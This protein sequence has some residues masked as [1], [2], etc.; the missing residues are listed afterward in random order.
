MHKVQHLFHGSIAWPQIASFVNMHT[1]VYVCECV[2]TCMHNYI[3]TI[4]C[5]LC[6]CVN[7]LHSLHTQSGS[8][9]ANPSPVKKNIYSKSH[10]ACSLAAKKKSAPHLTT[11]YACIQ[12]AV[13]TKNKTILVIGCK[14][15]NNKPN[16]STEYICCLCCLTQQDSKL[17]ASNTKK[18]MHTKK[19]V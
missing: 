15:W 13:W 12:I 8:E 5:M 11:M 1:C 10:V 6:M 18:D 16:I 14:N 3:H 2:W 19:Q 7:I 4:A 17:C 9:H